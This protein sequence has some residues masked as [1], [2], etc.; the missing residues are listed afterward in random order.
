MKKL[1]PL[2]FLCLL[3]AGCSTDGL[4]SP[5]DIRISSCQTER[6]LASETLTSKYVNG[7]LSLVHSY[8][9]VNCAATCSGEVKI[10]GDEIHVTEYAIGIAANCM[11]PVT[12]DF[13]IS[14]LKKGKNY[15]VIVRHST[16]KGSDGDVAARYKMI[17]KDGY[18]EIVL[19]RD[20]NY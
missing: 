19:N 2:L 1:L 20:S 12:Y 17:F 7:K 8:V 3:G 9:F 5:E 10:K 18:S 11:C 16:N 13:T 6:E 14:H 4:E 15:T